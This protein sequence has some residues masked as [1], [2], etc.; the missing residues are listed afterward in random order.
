MQGQ[1]A[2]A[3]NSTNGLS[4]SRSIFAA[5]GNSENAL[6]NCLRSTIALS[7]PEV[8]VPPT[9]TVISVSEK[10]HLKRKEWALELQSPDGPAVSPCR[11]LSVRSG[12]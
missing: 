10:R 4:Q 12:S 9:K 2:A 6:H 3:G 11:I 1:R 8:Q 5:Q 7:V